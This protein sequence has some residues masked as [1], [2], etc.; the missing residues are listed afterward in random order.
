MV[1]SVFSFRK[2]LITFRGF[3]ASASSVGGDGDHAFPFPVDAD[4]QMA[5]QATVGFL[6]VGHQPETSHPG[7]ESFRDS[8]CRFHGIRAFF[9]RNHIMGTGR[10]KTEHRSFGCSAAGQGG[11]VSVGIRV[12]HSKHRRNINGNASDSFKAVPDLLTLPLQRGF[13][14]HVAA[15][16]S[17]AAGPGGTPRIP[18]IRRGDHGGRFHPA[19]GIPFFRFHDPDVRFFPGQ[20]SGNKNRHPVQAADAFH[21]RAEFFG[22][23][24]VNL[25]FLHAAAPFSEKSQFFSDK[26]YQTIREKSTKCRARFPCRSPTYGKTPERP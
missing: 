9:R 12:F 19:E 10:V 5:D 14:T 8:P 25:I 2:R 20:H 24:T 1:F 7:Q 26:F 17:A 11:F 21:V 15:G 13:V 22:P 3:S 18:S 23:K 4:H 16:A 6:P